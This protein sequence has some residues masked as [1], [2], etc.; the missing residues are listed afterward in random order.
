[1]NFKMDSDI[2]SPLP[3]SNVSI[4]QPKRKIKYL[5]TLKHN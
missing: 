3:A 2:R 4:A 5:E 1:M